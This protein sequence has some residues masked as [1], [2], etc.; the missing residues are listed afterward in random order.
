MMA[1]KLTCWN[2]RGLKDQKKEDGLLCNLLFFVVYLDA[3]QE[4]HFVLVSIQYTCIGWPEEF[5]CR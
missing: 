4:T 2:V 3:I 5:P 1:I